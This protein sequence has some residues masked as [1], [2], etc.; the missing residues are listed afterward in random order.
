VRQVSPWF[1]VTRWGP[2]V[3]VAF[4]CSHLRLCS[5]TEGRGPGSG[6]GGP[7]I[8]NTQICLFSLT[9]LQWSGKLAASGEL[10][11][12]LSCKDYEG[13]RTKCFHLSRGLPAPASLLL[14]RVPSL[15]LL[16]TDGLEFLGAVKLQLNLL[17]AG[18][19]LSLI[20][21]FLVLPTVCFLAWNFSKAQSLCRCQ[22]L[23][24]K[25]LPVPP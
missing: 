13:W 5:L 10:R 8:G 6:L 9:G 11:N 12:F 18:G 20:P 17:Q 24:S 25:D 22:P 4:S 2:Q 15:K 1:P 19:S 14:G 21:S 16:Q 7:K 3:L 23:E